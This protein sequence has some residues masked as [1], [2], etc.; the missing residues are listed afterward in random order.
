MRFLMTYT[1]T[2]PAP[3][4]PEK[5]AAIQKFAE[6]NAKSGVLVD[7]GGM[8]PVAT[9]VKLASGKFAVTDGPF[10]ETKELIVGYAIVDVRSKEE[11]VELSR[12]FMSIAGDGEGELR[13]LSR[14]SDGPHH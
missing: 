2:N 9:R 10:P 5:M 4:T 1:A 7:T 6:D 14:P 3:P 11:A 8:L 13:Q 12:K